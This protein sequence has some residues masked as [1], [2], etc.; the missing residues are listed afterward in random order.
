MIALSVLHRL[1]T[2]A[3]AVTPRCELCANPLDDHH[4]HVVE[5]G[6]H[7]VRCA[8]AACAILF[9][10][11]TGRYRTVPDRVIADPAF[12]LDADQL[13]LP[14][15]LAFY[16]RDSARDT[17]VVRYPGPAGITEGELSPAGWAALATATQL[18]GELACDVEALLVRTR[19][20]GKESDTAAC[21][22][23]PIS[24]AYALAGRLRTTWR[25]FTGGDAAARELDDSFAKLEQRAR[26]R[27]GRR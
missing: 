22:L 19:R 6:V 21:Y 12:A 25:G 16:V 23:V 10:G 5:I 15:S 20:A 18:A 11:A 24:E 2:P 26:G 27:R 4:R 14:V 13:E 9:A 17:I 7:A 1:V 3:P 8:C